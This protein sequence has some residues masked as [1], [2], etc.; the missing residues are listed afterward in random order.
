MSPQ[1]HAL[2]DCMYRNDCAKVLRSKKIER[3]FWFHIDFSLIN[4][5]F[6]LFQSIRIKSRG[7]SPSLLERLNRFSL[8]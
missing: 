2:N 8:I 1:R 7:A 3:D 6:S 5:M 4:A